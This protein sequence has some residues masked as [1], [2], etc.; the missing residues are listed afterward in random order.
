MMEYFKSGKEYAMKINVSK[1][2]VLRVIKN[3]AS[4]TYF[5][6]EIL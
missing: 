6:K 5:W 2:N 3:E 4:L 1:T